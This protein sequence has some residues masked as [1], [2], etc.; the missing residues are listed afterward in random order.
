MRIMS[1][2]KTRLPSLR[3]QDWKTVKAETEKKLLFTHLSTNKITELNELIYA[4]VKLVCNKTGVSLKN[5]NRKSKHGWEYWLETQIRNLRQQAKMIK[6]EKNW[7]IL[8]RKENSNKSK[9]NNTTQGNK[10]ERTD[11]RKKTKKISRQDK[12]NTNKIGYSKITKEN[13]TSE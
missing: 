13:S 1:E 6:Q 4:G 9:T 5:T 7:N 3:N 2:K 10:P 11:E 8:G 12:N